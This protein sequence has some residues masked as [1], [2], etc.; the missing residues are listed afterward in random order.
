MAYLETSLGWAFYRSHIFSVAGYIKF[1]SPNSSVPDYI[2][3]I[4]MTACKHVLALDL[5]N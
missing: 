3:R 2:H 1:R 4:M 5:V